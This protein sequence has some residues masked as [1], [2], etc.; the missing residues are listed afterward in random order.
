MSKV[1]TGDF[2]WFNRIAAGEHGR[3]TFTPTAFDDVK[4]QP[5]PVWLNHQIPIGTAMISTNPLKASF[6]MEVSGSLLA[7]LETMFRRGMMSGCSLSMTSSDYESRVD[8]FGEYRIVRSVKKLIEVGPNSDPAER[9]TT[10]KI[11]DRATPVAS[12]SNRPM[13]KKRR[14]LMNVPAMPTAMK[15]GIRLMNAASRGESCRINGRKIDATTVQA[16][17]ANAGPYSIH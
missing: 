3:V 5:V 10:C 7:D 11:E 15:N 2:C 13:A 8:A 17:C 16:I 4:D 12:A 9:W 1:L 14:P 6:E